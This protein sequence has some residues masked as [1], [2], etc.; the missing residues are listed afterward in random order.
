MTAWRDDLSPAAQADADRL[1]DSAL[2]IARANLA[3]ASEFEP[4]AILVDEGGRLLGTDW[5]TSALGKHPEIEDV[6]AAALLQLREIG[7]TSRA[8]ALVTNSR[9][10][11][12][13]TDAI[14]VLF[15]HREGVAL[16]VLL[17]YKRA[18]FGPNIEFGE[19]S[20]FPGSREVWRSGG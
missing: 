4:F 15:E 19:L 14:E 7:R 3:R 12:E 16:V 17:P 13:K 11:R 5:D 2:T 8:T 9:L 1:I 6:I 20:A 10:A 18:R